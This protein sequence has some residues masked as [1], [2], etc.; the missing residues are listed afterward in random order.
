LI[1]LE[2]EEKVPGRNKGLLLF[3]AVLIL[4]SFNLYLL[5]QRFSQLK[6]APFESFNIGLNKIPK[7]HHRV[8]LQQQNIITNSIEKQYKQD[9]LAVFINSEPF[10]ERSFFFHLDQRNI[11]RDGFDTDDQVYEKSN[12]Y[13]I[14]PVFSNTKE[15]LKKVQDNLE[16]KN[17]ISFGTLNL[18]HLK[19]KTTPHL[20][21]NPLEMI[22]KDEESRSPL[23]ESKSTPQ[24]YSW[25]DAWNFLRDK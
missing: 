22:R 1:L 23:K 6:K 16:L 18:Y 9:G 13:M 21:K 10:Y 14:L 17:T 2:I 19:P 5:S 3:V 7:E 25:E 24:R 15:E 8:T 12:Y 11:P 4:A 20:Q